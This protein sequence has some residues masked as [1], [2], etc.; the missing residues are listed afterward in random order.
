MSF[1]NTVLITGG[2]AGLGFQTA[3][4]IAR[5][6]PEYLVVLASR[7]D[8]G[9]AAESIN[10]TLSQKNVTFLP[11]DLSSLTN[12]R[13]FGQA[14]KAKNF[15]PIIV[16]LLNAG[17]QFPRDLRQ[18][19][20][21][22][23]S[24]FAI[25]HVGHALLLHL[26][27]PNFASRARIVVT[28]SGAHDPAQ[29]TGLPDAKYTTAQEL[30]HPSPETAQNS[31]LQRY[32]TSKLV[33]IM[34]TYALHRRFT[35]LTEKKLTVTA[36]DPGLMPGTGIARENG[37]V[38]RMLWV[39]LLPRIIP[40]LRLV[41]R[42]IHSPQESATNLAWLAVSD[43]VEGVSGIYY[44]GNNEIKSSEESYD[45]AKQEDLWQWTVKNIATEESEIEKFE[46]AN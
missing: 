12:V 42:N 17:T 8:P 29:K 19:G 33:N 25:N 11:L 44:E 20:D 6:H 46:I 32:T 5:E 40:V 36:F 38:F 41:S 14:W 2:T 3:L 31:G 26:I 4:I 39:H 10:N 28:S 21:G 13:T 9:S 23:E 35:K 7:T 27:Y 16:L 18:T 43:D 37:R 22:I 15:P 1:S 34:W 45:K 24:T 30:A